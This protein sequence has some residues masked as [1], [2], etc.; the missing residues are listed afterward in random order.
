MFIEFRRS[1]SILVKSCNDLCN[2]NRLKTT[3]PLYILSA[4]TVKQNV[5]SFKLIKIT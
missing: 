4:V 1:Y 2:L 3:R 5:P